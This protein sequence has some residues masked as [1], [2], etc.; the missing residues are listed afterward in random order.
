MKKNLPTCTL[1]KQPRLYAVDNNPNHLRAE[2][3]IERKD[4]NKSWYEQKNI[5]ECSIE[6]KKDSNNKGV[7]IITHTAPE[8]KALAEFAVKTKVEDF[9]RKKIIN[10]NNAV[11]HILFK[12]FTNEERIVFFFRLSTRSDNTYFKYIDI[13]DIALKPESDKLPEKISWMNRIKKLI[14]SG[15]RLGDAFFIK[16]KEY[17]KHIIVWNIEAKFEYTYNG[18]IGECNFNFGFPEFGTKQKLD[19]EFEMNIST[20]IPRNQKLDTKQKGILKNKL[21][22]EMDKQKTIVYS[23]FNDYLLEKNKL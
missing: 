13:V 11:K 10:S 15:Q 18:S 20:P 1:T 23:K 14:I 5:F 17:H 16:E 19:S 12:D 22:L 7:V 6:F 4:L 2:I 9:K 8:T 21:L 3:E